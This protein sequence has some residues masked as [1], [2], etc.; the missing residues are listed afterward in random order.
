MSLG[1]FVAGNYIESTIFIMIKRFRNISRK[2]KGLINIL[3][4]LQNGKIKVVDT[5]YLFK[6]E[7]KIEVLQ[8]ENDKMMMTF[9]GARAANQIMNELREILECPVGYDIIEAAK[10]LKGNIDE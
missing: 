2:F 4:Q 3:S 1:G 10:K 6:L 5:E 8:K 9:Y 7:N